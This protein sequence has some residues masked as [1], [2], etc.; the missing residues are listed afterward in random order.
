M[1]EKYFGLNRRPFLAKV[2]GGDV[3]VGPQTARTMAGLRKALQV[4]DAVVLVAGPPGCGKSTLVSKALEAVGETHR[5]LRI[6]RMS[7][8]GSDL[9]EYL[10]EELGETDLP[11]GPIRQFSLFREKLAE[12]ESDG[13]RI[14]IVIEDALRL[15]AD[16]LAELEALTAADAGESNGAALVVMGDGRLAQVL[17]D[18][19][20]T[21]LAQRL[22][23]THQVRPMS[24]PELRG[25][26]MHC[27]RQAGGDF[28]KVFAPDVPTAIREL[29]QGITRIAN[30][31]VEA[32]L[33]A[34]AASRTR[35]LSG[36]FVADVAGREFGL[37]TH[38]PVASEPAPAPVVH[39]Q[40]E[41]PSDDAQAA[42]AQAVEQPEETP[43]PTAAEAA[44]PVIV[45]AD[46]T[47]E[48]EDDDIPELIQ[49]TLPGL[50]VLTPEPAAT[51]PLPEPEL[52][53]EPELEPE[54]EAEPVAIQETVADADEPMAAPEEPVVAASE[55]SSLPE[56][57]LA[58]DDVIAACQPQ[59]VADGAEVSVASSGSEPV[60]AAAPAEDSPTDEVPD[61]EKDPTLAEL[62]PDLDALE[63]AMAV[64]H[65][66]ADDAE[67]A[68]SV[69]MPV[70][71]PEPAEQPEQSE[72]IPE[73]TLD[74]A[75][76]QR[77]DNNL[78]DEPGS[79]SAS[80][81]MAV[82][83]S[84][85][86]GDLP[87]VKLPPRNAKKADAELER[88]AAELAKAKTIED[89]DDK[90]AETLFGE[91]LSLAAA[92]VAALV[93]AEQSSNDEDLSLFD[94]NAA[95][96][97][98]AV[99]SPVVDGVEIALESPQGPAGLDPSASQRLHTVRS[100]TPADT[101]NA[102]GP[103]GTPAEYVSRPEIEESTPDP[104]EDQINTSMTQTLKA[105][106][107][108]PPVLD[109]TTRIG[110]DQP[111]DD[112]DDEHEEQKKKGG[113][114]SRFRRS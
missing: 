47:S 30:K 100:L 86:S 72:V 31:I 91:E 108:K 90:L 55:S 80:Q 83:G 40:D 19:Q 53:P 26:L 20:L 64:A 71:Q 41:S 105:L 99:G 39:P 82:A 46:E 113:F 50:E 81:D 110:D 27:I 8:R 73:I 89:V 25:Y 37:K 66:D 54:P 101:E 102:P 51:D 33:S 70:L 68:D 7:L 24:E 62:M 3:F 112:D 93:R 97:A 11:H 48:D 9:V 58:I 15:G 5:T 92:E 94:T 17:P 29:S 13:T 98:Q 10:L 85:S 103:V 111:D 18:P 28:D 1:Y 21:R 2:S 74:N 95:Q 104:I 52:V 76:R 59:E 60:A 23:H 61:W 75:I 6:G 57:E 87:D 107:V 79:V 63:K 56:L 49:D 32:A 114:F 43:E 77:I 69:D 35:P 67:D 88:I 14:V 16:L 22:Q 34:A 36:A 109:R 12:L 44:E 84:T 4:Q 65:G 96:M 45:F 78:I 42:A 106:N 38:P